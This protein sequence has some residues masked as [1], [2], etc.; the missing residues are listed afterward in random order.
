MPPGRSIRRPPPS[1]PNK[2]KLPDETG[3]AAPDLVK[4]SGELIS[5][6]SRIRGCTAC[7]RAC[8]D[9]TFGTGYPRAPIM[10]V[11]EHP[12][13]ADI[14]SGGAFTEEADA[15]TKAFE[16]L[17]I[18]L[19]WVYGSTAV[20][21]GDGAADDT[22]MR[23]CAVHVLIELEAVLPRVVVA[24]G[25]KTVEVFRAVDGQC[26]IRVPDD[27]TSGEAVALRSDLTLVVTEPL[28]EGV[29]QKDAKRRLWRDLQ[30]VGGL[31]GR[32]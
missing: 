20:R 25:A 32:A 6:T 22:Q 15:L 8:D 13:A 7:D 26:G 12:S 29:T 16:A 14:E 17:G 31:I 19:S 5:L 30:V 28:P 11:K 18:P 27:V 21:C 2:P 10:L 9:R 3:S 1:R 24:F 23:A 4:A